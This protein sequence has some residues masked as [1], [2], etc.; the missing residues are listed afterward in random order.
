MASKI[1]I[2]GHALLGMIL[3]AYLDAEDCPM[4]Y[5]NFIAYKQKLWAI[6]SLRV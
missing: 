6:R 3:K 4:K 1:S 2:I 5:N